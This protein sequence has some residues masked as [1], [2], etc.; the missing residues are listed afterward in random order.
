M[1]ID[2]N[3]LN[4][5]RYLTTPVDNIQ[6][7]GHT[8]YRSKVTNLKTHCHGITADIFFD[9]VT[10]EFIDALGA[11][12]STLE[13]LDDSYIGLFGLEKDVMDYQVITNFAA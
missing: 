13:I 6:G 5:G 8:S 4:L 2:S 10:S 11:K 9:R 1:L 12:E 3:L 7:G